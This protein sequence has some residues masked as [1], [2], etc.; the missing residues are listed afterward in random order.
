MRKTYNIHYAPPTAKTPAAVTLSG[1]YEVSLGGKTI[2][3]D[4]PPAF[5]EEVPIFPENSY[6]V[7]NDL[8]K[9]LNLIQKDPEYKK[10][11]AATLLTKALMYRKLELFEENTSM[12]NFVTKAVLAS[13]HVLPVEETQRISRALDRLDMGRI[14]TTASG[15]L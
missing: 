3:I 7:S 4:T 2:A 5:G 13:C 14:K 6:K 8:A 11:N 10:E 12:S 15:P 9:G 1:H